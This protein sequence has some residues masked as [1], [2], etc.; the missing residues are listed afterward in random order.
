M[1]VFCLYLEKEQIIASG[2]SYPA[3]YDVDPAID[4]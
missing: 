1:W 2:F 4:Q 3:E